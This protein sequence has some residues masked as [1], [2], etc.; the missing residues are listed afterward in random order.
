SGVTLQVKPGR[1]IGVKGRSGSGKTT[2]LNCVGGLDHPSSGLVRCFGREITRM[3]D[4]ELT[5]WRRK[6]VG[7]VFQSFALLPTLS[8]SENIELPIRIAGQ[9]D[10]R[11]RTKYCLDLV[12]LTKWA[13]H[14]PYEMSG[15]QQQRVA[16]ARA[17]ANRPKL[18]LADEPTGELDT[19]TAR[20]IL[21]LF[22]RIVEMEGVTMLMTS[23]DPIVLEY[24]DE[25]IEL[26]DGQRVDSNGQ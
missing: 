22:R 4:G 3:S 9:R 16:I 13:S 14:R 8:A 7:F 15:G 18:I 11:A 26:Q 10:R 2:L 1:W 24:V 5:N 20:D 25:V 21:S 6:Q 12:G 17:L 19:T 23:H